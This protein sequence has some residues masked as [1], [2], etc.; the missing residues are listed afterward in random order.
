MKPITNESKGT[1]GLTL[2]KRANNIILFLL[3]IPILGL[4]F[5]SQP[6]PNFPSSIPFSIIPMSFTIVIV[7]LNLIAWKYLK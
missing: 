6:G 4:V 2:T 7:S 3:S 1:K 5:S